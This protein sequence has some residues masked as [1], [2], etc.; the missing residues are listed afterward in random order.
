MS[1][2]TEPKIGERGPLGKLVEYG[3][4]SGAICIWHSDI[5]RPDLPELGDEGALGVIDQIQQERIFNEGEHVGWQTIIVWR[6]TE[7]SV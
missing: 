1:D 4:H 7:D 2:T 5:E 6:T 3:S